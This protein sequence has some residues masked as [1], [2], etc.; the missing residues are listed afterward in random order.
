MN[1]ASIP[2]SVEEL[3]GVLEAFKKR[4][5]AAKAAVK[6]SQS[7]AAKR[8]ATAADRPTIFARTGGKC[9]VC[10]GQ[11]KFTDDW[12][13]DH[14][15]AHSGGGTS[16]ADN[17]LPAHRRC[18]FYRW[19]RPQDEFEYVWAL[20]NWLQRE[21]EGQTGIGRQAAAEFAAYEDRRK[22]RRKTP[23]P[24]GEECYEL[25]LG[26]WIR[27]QIEKLTAIGRVAGTAYVADLQR[28]SDTRGDGEGNKKKEQTVVSV[29]CD[30]S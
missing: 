11:M 23:D 10:G 26:V 27:T 12:E 3:A 20:G 5:Y 6:A 15:V 25:K 14:V 29:R 9:H 2:G 16:D 22:R 30:Y 19:D 8:A 28:A 7:Q 4:R 1:R 21:V 24:G 18:N 13:A 17:F